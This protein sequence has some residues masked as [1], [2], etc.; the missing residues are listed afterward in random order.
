MELRDHNLS[1]VNPKN[2]ISLKIPRYIKTPDFSPN[3]AEIPNLATN[4]P[5]VET[6]VFASPIRGHNIV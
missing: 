3:D 6:L 1:Q 5:E 4:F 2:V